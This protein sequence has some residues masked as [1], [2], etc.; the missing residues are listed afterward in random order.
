MIQHPIEISYDIALSRMFFLYIKLVS[1]EI[2]LADD[3]AFII[4]KIKVL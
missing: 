1:L 4:E 2:V 3:Y